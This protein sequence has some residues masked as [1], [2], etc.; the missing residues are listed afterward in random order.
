MSE[1]AI[2]TFFEDF[3]Q[4]NAS[5]D[6]EGLVRLYAASFLMARPNGVQVVKAADLLPAIPK[7]KQLLAAIGCRS[8][9]LASLQE[10]K[11]DDRYSIVRTEWRWRFDRGGDGPEEIT[12]PSTFI[13]QQSGEGLQIVFYLAHEDILAVLRERGWLPAS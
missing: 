11:L 2:R 7:R 5:G 8:T 4:R 3:A 12:L 6:A 1:P 10:T 9:T 13:V